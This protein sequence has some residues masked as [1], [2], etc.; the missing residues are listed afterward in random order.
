MKSRC[1]LWVWGEFQA[2]RADTIVL[3]K[4]RYSPYT[5]YADRWWWRR[6]IR[7]V[8][9][10]LIHPTWL[11]MQALYMSLDGRWMHASTCSKEFIPLEPKHESRVREVM[12]FDGRVAEID[13]PCEEP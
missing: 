4:T 11:M 8:G 7:P 12:G 6:F 13:N 1:D 2:G 3:R 5:K 10:L 9:N